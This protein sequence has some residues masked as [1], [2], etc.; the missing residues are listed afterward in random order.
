M[1][2][3]ILNLVLSGFS[4]R[5]FVHKKAILESPVGFYSFLNL[6][7]YKN[8]DYCSGAIFFKA[9]STHIFKINFLFFYT[10]LVRFRNYLFLAHR[11]ICPCVPIFFRPLPPVSPPTWPHR[12]IFAIFPRCRKPSAQKMAPFPVSLV[13]VS[14]PASNIAFPTG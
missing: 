10:V 9:S 11:T 3:S 1:K 4:F 7:L 12:R 13:S 5:N 2:N 14:Q 8:S 6:F